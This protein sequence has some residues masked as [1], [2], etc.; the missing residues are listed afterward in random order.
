MTIISKT[1]DLA[2]ILNVSTLNA[3]IR[4]MMIELR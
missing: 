2:I 4:V 1:R 3:N